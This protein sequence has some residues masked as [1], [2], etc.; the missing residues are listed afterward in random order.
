MTSELRHDKFFY[1][2]KYFSLR[3]FT[4]ILDGIR[5]LGINKTLLVFYINNF[6]HKNKKLINLR[7]IKYI[8][9]KQRGCGINILENSSYMG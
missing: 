8:K 7:S 1:H 4:N 3:N 6:S 5:Q 2:T 9:T